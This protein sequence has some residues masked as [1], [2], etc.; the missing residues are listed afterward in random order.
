ME[1]YI[2]ETLDP[3]TRVIIESH[4]STCQ[5]CDRTINELADLKE[6]IEFDERELNRA[7]VA[8]PAVIPR[9]SRFLQKRSIL[10]IFRSALPSLGVRGRLAR[11]PNRGP[12]VGE[13]SQWL[14]R[15]PIFEHATRRRIVG[16]A[17]QYLFVLVL[18]AAVVLVGLR[19]V[20]NTLNDL[21]RETERLRLENEQLRQ[22]ALGS[23]AVVAELQDRINSVRAGASAASSTATVVAKIKDGKRSIGLS[24]DGRLIGLEAMPPIYQEAVN[25]V[26]KDQRALLAP[27]VSELRRTSARTTMAPTTNDPAFRQ[28]GPGGIVVETNPPIFQWTKLADARGYEVTIYD[29]RSEIVIT[30]GVLN[31]TEWQPPS[32][33]EGGRRYGWQVRAYKENG[34]ETKIPAVGHREVWFSVLTNVTA[35]ELAHA[36]RVAGDSHLVMGTL[37][38]QAGLVDAALREFRELQK[39]NPKS[40][41]ARTFG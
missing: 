40:P 2:N 1:A 5:E 25:R 6:A 33:L 30:S 24:E 29:K 4:I 19:G 10:V 11:S 37:Y 7:P 34:S 23:E 13:A 18:S 15:R 27:I 17:L 14:S 21:R 20:K 26:L 16:L 38:A 39:A 32:P 31:Q 41:I 36:K 3:S 12:L 22:H 9:P 8:V 28:I 35:N